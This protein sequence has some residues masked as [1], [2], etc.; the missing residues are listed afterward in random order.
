MPELGISVSNLKAPVV[1]QCTN[2]YIRVCII[3]LPRSFTVRGFLN[4]L[5]LSLSLK[6]A[7]SVE[8]EV[9]CGK[10]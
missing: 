8:K 9:Q 5:S 7:L 2:M 4:P 10:G 6:E 3:Y 1:L